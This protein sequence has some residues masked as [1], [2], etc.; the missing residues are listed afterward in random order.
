[1]HK[2]TKFILILFISL[3]LAFSL[4][5]TY[6]KFNNLSLFDDKIIIAYGLNFLV[7]I[8][9][10]LSLYFFKKKYLEQLGFLYMGGSFLKFILFFIFFYPTYKQDGEMS[11]FEFAAFFIP[12]CISLIIE[13]LGVIN[14]LKK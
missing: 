1:M 14:F 6:L 7:A 5:I 4:H 8:L 13:T 3:A 9:I 2:I 10:Y 12:Y 11:S